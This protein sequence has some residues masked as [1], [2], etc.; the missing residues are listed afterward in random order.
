MQRL[1]LVTIVL[2]INVA[3]FCQPYGF[4]G[5]P[6]CNPKVGRRGRAQLIATIPCDLS[7][8]SYCN[9][10]GSLYPWHAVRRFVHENQGLMKRM[11]G[12]VKHISVL[13]TE[14]NNNDIDVDDVEIAA[15]RYSRS[16]WKKNKYLYN[17]YQNNKNNDVLTEP[18]FRPTST[19]TTTKSAQT[20]TQT[21]PSSGSRTTIDEST[22][23]HQPPRTPLNAGKTI[24]DENAADVTNNIYDNITVTP[25]EANFKI[26]SAPNLSGGKNTSE[27]ATISTTL[28]IFLPAK[29][30]EASITPPQDDIDDEAK[31]TDSS[32]TESLIATIKTTSTD[33]LEQVE[34]DQ[35][36][37]ESNIYYQEDSSE[38]LESSERTKDTNAKQANQNYRPPIVAQSTEHM[39]GQLFQDVVQKEAPAAPVLNTRGV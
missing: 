5:S 30:T 39:E 10:P 14:I 32:S 25:M 28:R 17:D 8:Q 3:H 35:L 15:A 29:H 21:V 18:Y 37:S 31:T 9:L 38:D 11:Y 16:G 1:I 20:A 27:T 6:S 13:R 4:D 33:R 12:D 19:S 23:T 34:D 26:V 36:A 24:T 2:L 7:V 22:T